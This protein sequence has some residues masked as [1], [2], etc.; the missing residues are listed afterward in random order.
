MTARNRRAWGD[1]LSSLYYLKFL[2]MPVR[3]DARYI[4]TSPKGDQSIVKI[5][6][7][8]EVDY[9]NDLEKDGFSYKEVVPAQV[10]GGTCVSCEG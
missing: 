5:T 6:K 10:V 2:P 4:R 7:Q 9:H 8:T 3:I 1:N